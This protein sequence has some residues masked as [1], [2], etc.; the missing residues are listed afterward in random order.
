[1]ALNY[2]QVSVG[3]TATSI[4]PSNTDAKVRKINNLGTNTI[5][6][7]SDSSITTSNA[8]PI[9]VGETLDISDYTGEVFGIVAASTED[10]SY[11]EEDF[12]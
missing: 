5:F 10:A 4:I 1:M 7:G 8:F 9:E 3:N 6:V 12:Q 2:N 11:I